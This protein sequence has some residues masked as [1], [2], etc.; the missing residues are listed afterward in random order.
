MFSDTTL[1]FP[2]IFDRQFASYIENTEI[3]TELRE[4]LSLLSTDY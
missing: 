4:M 2:V 1:A 3:V